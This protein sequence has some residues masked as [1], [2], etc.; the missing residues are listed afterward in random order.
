[1]ITFAGMS[2]QTAPLDI[3][4][5]VAI[6]DEALPGVL[7]RAKETFGA[8]TIIN[9]CNRL[10]LYL[11]GIHEPEAALGF[12]AVELDVDHEVMRRQFHV[13]YDPDAVPHLYSV[14][15]GIR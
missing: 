2:H 3:R 12:L 10:E 9:T 7:Q 5:R 15:S 6:D 14:A 13:A 1:M 11:P 8:A 4:E